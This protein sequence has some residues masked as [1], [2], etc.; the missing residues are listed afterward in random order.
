MMSN[1][2]TVFR[3]NLSSVVLELQLYLKQ[4]FVGTIKSLR[5]KEAGS[6]IH[7][8]EGF[9]IFIFGPNFYS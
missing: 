3:E 5:S 9:A 1:K 6:K 7:M 2:N 4:V 8:Q